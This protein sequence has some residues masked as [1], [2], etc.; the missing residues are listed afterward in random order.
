MYRYCFYLEWDG[1]KPEVWAAW[2]QAIGS[3]AALAVAVGLAMWQWEKA[4][5]L[6]RDDAKLRAA[7]EHRIAVSLAAKL[8]R[9]VKTF[10]KNTDEISKAYYARSP[11]Q[12]EWQFRIPVVPKEISEESHRLHEMG[13]PGEA[14]IKALYHTVEMRQSLTNDSEYMLHNS[15][16]P[17]FESH[18]D[19][20]KRHLDAAIEAMK[21]LL[22]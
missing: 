7:N 5:D 1:W 3:V 16:T 20:A 22:A 18:L 8:F 17:E 9:A 4:M 13:P 11:M 21:S 2:I 15:K 19:P 12:S 10:Q 6:R 14:I